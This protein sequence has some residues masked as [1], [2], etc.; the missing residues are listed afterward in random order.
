MNTLR[1]LNVTVH[2]P[3]TLD[4]STVEV[5]TLAWLAAVVP[6]LNVRDIALVVGDEL[7]ETPPMLRSRYFETQFLKP[8]FA[9]YFD[10]GARWS[11]MPRPLMTNRSFDRSYAL[12]T[13]GG[14]TEPIHHPGTHPYDV[15]LEMMWD[16]AQCL[17]V[18]R[19]LVVNIATKNHAMPCDWLER[20]LQGRFRIH[21]AYKLCDS[22]IDSM[23][24]ALAP[25]PLLVRSREVADYLPEAMRNWDMIVAPEPTKNSFP[26]YNDDD[27]LLSSLYIDVNVLSVAPDV[28]LGSVPK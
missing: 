11:V 8:I 13:T 6:P 2:R 3:M 22:H 4:A 10:R 14:P 24:I 21:R 1:K 5:R 12:S 26:A 18:G 20:H 7:I 27:L 25:G 17:R 19:D 16:G 23:V 28:V 15:G 9:S